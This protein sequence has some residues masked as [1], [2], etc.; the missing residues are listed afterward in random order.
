[1]SL[2]KIGNGLIDICF[3][4]A[5]GLSL[6]LNLRPGLFEANG[7]IAI[8][9]TNEDIAQVH[10][11]GVTVPAAGT[12]II[13]TTGAQRFTTVQATDG[14]AA[15]LARG[16][17]ELFSGLSPQEQAQIINW[18]ATVPPEADL[19]GVPDATDNCPS[20]A[21]ADQ[22]DTD[23][24]GVGNACDAD[25]DGDG[26]ADTTEV[27]RGTDSLKADTDADGVGDN[28]DACPTQAG[29]LANGCVDTVK[30][31]TT[32]TTKTLLKRA[33][34]KAG[35]RARAVCTESCAVQFEL[36]GRTT[37]GRLNAI[38]DVVWASRRFPQGIVAR[39][40]TLKVPAR[41]VG[42]A[43]RFAIRL[44]VTTTDLSGNQTVVTRT[45]RVR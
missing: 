28:T 7:R 44:R 26:T 17:A 1:M 39:S 38:G 27:S 8:I 11:T 4:L 20:V 40:A 36:V 29:L 30:P 22:L 19:D 24:D 35:V 10:F 42:S 12:V 13:M 31:V 41:L 15:Q 5:D 18:K 33:A 9:E 14:T 23:R 3:C 34:F 6:L 21:N 16:S 32:V 45:I 25:D 2:P 37:G 43:K